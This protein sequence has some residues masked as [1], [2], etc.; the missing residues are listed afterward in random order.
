MSIVIVEDRFELRELVGQILEEEGYRVHSFGHPTAVRALSTAG[1]TPRL[2]LIDIML[3]DMDG[4]ALAR[5]L[6]YLGFADTPKIAISASNVALAQARASSQFD[7]VIAKP[8]DVEML[9]TTIDRY[10]PP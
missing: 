1:D 6:R 2:F 5:L 4:I 3:P 9:L 8:F 10:L 7:A